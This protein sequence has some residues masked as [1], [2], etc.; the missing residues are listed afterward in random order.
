MKD[1]RFLV[2]TK[3]TEKDYNKF[4]YTATFRRNKLVLLIIGLMSML[5][6]GFVAY[7]ETFNYLLF[8]I[9]WPALFA[10]S[11]G[12]I[13]FKVKRDNNKLAKKHNVGFYDNEISFKFYENHLLVENPQNKGNKQSKVS[14]D[15]FHQILESKDYYILYLTYNQASLIRKKDL[16]D[17][18]AF[19][20]FILDRF[21]SI[22]RKI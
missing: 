1:I 11:I 22:Y 6:A 16:E 21:K 7:K 10:L 12:I 20:D 13:F 8:L 15:K 18:I 14:Y 2:K 9:S 3:M 4:L 5:G 17:P 19:N